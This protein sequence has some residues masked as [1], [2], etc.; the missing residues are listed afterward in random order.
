MITKDLFKKPGNALETGLNEIKGFIE[1]KTAEGSIPDELCVLCPSCNKTLFKDD[2]KESLGVCPYCNH[3]Y[4]IGARARIEFLTDKKSFLEHDKNFT[5]CN[6]LSF[7]DYDEKIV[8]AKAES[9]ENE[10]VITGVCKIGGYQCALFVMEPRYIMG[11]MGSIVGEKITRIFEYATKKGLPV[12]GY[13]VSGGARMQEGIVSLMQMAKVSGAVKY[14]SDAGNLYIAC[15]TNPTTG[16]VT[17]SF[18]MLADIIVS[19]PKALIGFAGPRV[20]EQ[21]IRQKLP[22]GFQKAEYLL[23]TGFIDDIIERKAQK[24]YFLKLLKIH[25]GGQ[26]HGADSI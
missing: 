5:S 19:E 18:A 2:L 10:A 17:A 25:S 20:I 8:K 23:E 21:T 3:Y 15:L 22:E 26:K 16:G 14:H 11:S 12:I 1:K 13:T 6:I 4:K 24:D 7:P 9:R